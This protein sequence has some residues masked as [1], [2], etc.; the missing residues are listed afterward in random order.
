MKMINKKIAVL[1]ALAV[2]MLPV[3]ANAMSSKDNNNVTAEDRRVERLENRILQRIFT[4]YEREE[5]ENYFEDYYDDDGKT[6]KKAKKGLPPGLAKRDTLPPGLQKQ[7]EKNGRLP[8][9]LEKRMLPDNLESRLPARAENL[10]RRIVG[11]DVVLI[12]EDTD[13]ILDIIYNV[14]RP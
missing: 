4:D 11:D 9:G 1:S 5:I 8:P 2:L 14:L 6:S 13:L 10:A 3:G 12:D 7:L